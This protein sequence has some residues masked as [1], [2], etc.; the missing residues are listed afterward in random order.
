MSILNKYI[1]KLWNYIDSLKYR[2]IVE[3]VFVRG[4]EIIAKFSCRYIIP[5]LI[6]VH[7]YFQN[8]FF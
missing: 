2:L 4:A 6:S 8:F 1:K 7:V 5:K 3:L